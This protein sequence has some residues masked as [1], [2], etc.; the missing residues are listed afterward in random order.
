MADIVEL[1]L[2]ARRAELPGGLHVRRA[3]PQ[4]QRRSVGPFVFVDQMGPADFPP[5]GGADVLSHPHIGLS[6]LTWL[7]EG[8]GLHKDSLGSVQP[9]R[10]GEV[11]WMTAGRG[12][13]HA[14]FMRGGRE[15][16]LY[17]VQTWVALPRA[18]EECEPSFTHYGVEAVPVL[19]EKGVRMKL[20]AGAL[21]GARS[22]VRVSSPLFYVEA[23][24]EA[25]AQLVFPAE[26]EERAL[27]VVEGSIALAERELAPGEMAFFARGREVRIAARTPSLLLLLGGEPLDGPRYISWNFVSSS[28]ERLE[29]A[30]ED[31]RHHRFPRI[32]G[33][34]AYIPLPRDGSGPVNY[35]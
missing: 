4:R 9:L 1:V 18:D 20:I 8:E 30:A 10:P 28:R 35:P 25:G 17:G 7:F 31:W 29:Q 22:E 33:E 11:N 13:V 5:D 24:M 15:R 19:E 23:R 16:R 27:Y 14:E 6:T 21:F 26:Y 32:P 2:E 3:I 34:T 12:I